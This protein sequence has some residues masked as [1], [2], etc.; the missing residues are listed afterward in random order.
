MKDK[1]DSWFVRKHLIC[2][3]CG[4]LLSCEWMS[5]SLDVEDACPKGLYHINQVVV[6]DCESKVVVNG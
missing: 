1:D 6:C 2:S 3:E 5:I 4:I